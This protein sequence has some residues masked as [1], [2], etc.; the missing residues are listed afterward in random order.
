MGLKR[1]PWKRQ[2]RTKTLRG[3]HRIFLPN[4]EQC[5]NYRAEWK[6]AE[7]LPGGFGFEYRT[8]PTPGCGWQWK[9]PLEPR[10]ALASAS[11]LRMEIGPT[12]PLD[13]RKSL[14]HERKYRGPN[15]LESKEQPWNHLLSLNEGLISSQ[16]LSVLSSS[17]AGSEAPPSTG[18]EV[19]APSACTKTE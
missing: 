5:T 18:S 3:N 6:E 1:N 19:S 16:A 15:E 17:L 13:V 9:W 11:R 2:P 8:A 4:K 14:P 7:P 12:P 10:P